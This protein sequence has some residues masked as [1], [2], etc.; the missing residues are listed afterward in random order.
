[1]NVSRL[2]ALVAA[3]ASSLVLCSCANSSFQEVTPKGTDVTFEM[4]TPVK[5][6]TEG[7][8]QYFLSKAGKAE[9][10]VSVFMRSSFPSQP[11]ASDVDVLR[12]FE[13]YYLSSLQEGWV[14]KGFNPQINYEKELPGVHGFG[15]QIR[16]QLGQQYSL[17]RFYISPTNLYQIKV[18][19]G[20]ESNP[21]VKRFFESIEI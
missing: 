21:A 8:V 17:L 12:D 20:D 2:V 3:F 19:N 10:R 18:D 9:I 5:S 6:S 1:M 16:A 15:Q 4:P 13:E 11:G 14:Q 7:Q